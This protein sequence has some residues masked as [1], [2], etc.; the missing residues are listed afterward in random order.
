MKVV[1]LGKKGQVSIPE[2]V[3]SRVGLEGDDLLS[4][5][6]TDDGAIILRPADIY[7]VEM[8][9]DERVEGFLEEDDLSS[10]REG[11]RSAR[12]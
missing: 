6:A 12:S 4:V 5:E 11:C 8:Y 2:A 3:L 10:W 7:P 9:S 1:K